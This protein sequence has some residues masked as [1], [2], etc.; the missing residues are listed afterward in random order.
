MGLKKFLKDKNTSPGLL[1]QVHKTRSS[2]NYYIQMEN[3]LGN[4]PN[5]VLSVTRFN[6]PYVYLLTCLVEMH[7]LYYCFKI[8]YLWTLSSLSV[9]LNIHLQN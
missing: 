4:F 1:I 3:K 2:A 8:A 5:M 9:C 6:H 7:L